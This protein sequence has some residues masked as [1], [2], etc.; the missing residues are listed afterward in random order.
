MSPDQNHVHHILLKLN[1]SHSK[2]TLALVGF[3]VSIVGVAYSLQFLGNNWLSLIVLF[4]AILFGATLDFILK[5]RVAAGKTA[6][7][8]A[9][10]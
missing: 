6:K 4:I 7:N 8:P 10:A 1:L 5:K 3:N 9:L 2:S